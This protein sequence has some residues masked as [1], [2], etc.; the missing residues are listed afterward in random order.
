MRVD[1]AARITE[2]VTVVHR[3]GADGRKVDAWRAT[4]Y[5]AC[6]WQDVPTRVSSSDGS[7]GDVP[8]ILVQI[9]E[10]QGTP[11][12]AL[13]DWVVRGEFAPTSAGDHPTTAEL[14]EQV[15]EAAGRVSR[16]R[17]LTGGITGAVGPIARYASVWVLEAGR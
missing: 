8:S 11:E 4:T 12:V 13:G 7:V 10:D 6:D 9:P 5:P 2:P 14:L 16:I 17:D 15:P 1:V 3:M